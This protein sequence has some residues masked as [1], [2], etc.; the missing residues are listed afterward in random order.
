[1]LS[2]YYIAEVNVRMTWLIGGIFRNED[3]ITF[4]RTIDGSNNLLEFFVPEG[5]VEEFLFL[6]DYLMKHHLIYS[7]QEAPNRYLQTKTT[8][9]PCPL[10]HRQ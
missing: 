8:L 5:Q 10:D 3:N 2:T 4:E 1:M 9:S 6:V 7:I